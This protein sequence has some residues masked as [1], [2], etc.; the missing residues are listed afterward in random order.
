[1]ITL[2]KQLDCSCHYIYTDKIFIKVNI[3][4]DCTVKTDIDKIKDIL[5]NSDLGQKKDEI[6]ND[7]NIAA[8]F[9]K[10]KVIVLKLLEL[11]TK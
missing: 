11:K 2:T 1:M 7:T 8:C 4:S 6:P 9:F 5:N 10:A 3:P